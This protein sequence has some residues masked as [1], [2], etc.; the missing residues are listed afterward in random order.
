MGVGGIKSKYWH[1]VFV[2][3][4]TTAC[5]E[6]KNSDAGTNVQSLDNIRCRG[7]I[8]T[9]IKKEE[10]H[11]Q[12]E[13]TKNVLSILVAKAELN[14]IL[15]SQGKLHQFSNQESIALIIQ[16]IISHIC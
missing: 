5:I 7:K 2:D 12:N 8:A 13:D 6:R 9:I 1:P 14:C 4:E 3:G 15:G 11:L 16:R 10:I